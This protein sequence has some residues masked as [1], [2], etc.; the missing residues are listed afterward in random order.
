[1]IANK[2]RTTR[3][4]RK[5]AEVLGTKNVPSKIEGPFDFIY[6]AKA[7]VNVDVVNNFINY[8]NLS[9]AVAAQIL[10]ISEPTLYRW[11]KSKKNLEKN[12]SVKL[13]EIVDLFLLGEEVFGTRNSFF[14]WMK[15]PNEALGGMEPMELIEIP[16]G[17]SKVRDV[18]GRIEYGVFS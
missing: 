16:G 6:L 11:S 2:D 3:H 5:L 8:F 10:D 15:L 18:L 12:F 14:T 13:F 1:M 17:V 9:K 7:G 4:Y